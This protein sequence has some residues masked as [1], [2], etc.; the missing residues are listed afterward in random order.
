MIHHRSREDLRTEDMARRSR[1]GRTFRKRCRVELEE[2]MDLL[3]ARIG[4][5]EHRTGGD[6]GPE[7]PIECVG[8]DDLIGCLDDCVTDVRELR[9]K[10]KDARS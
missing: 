6:Q 7:G 10:V 9:K 2:R 3:E 8:C 4:R 5:L 1:D